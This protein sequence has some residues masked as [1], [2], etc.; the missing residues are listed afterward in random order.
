MKKTAAE[1][2]LASLITMPTISADTVANSMAI[3]YIESYLAKRGMHCKRTEFGGHSTLLASSRPDNQHE[4]VVLLSGHTDVVAGTEEQFHLKIDGDRLIGRGTFDMKFAIA[5]YMQFVDEIKDRLAEYDFAILIVSD[6]ETTDVG[7]QGHIA[8][9]LRPQVCILPDST[10]PNWDIESLAKGYRRLDLIAE[11]KAAHG[12]RPWEGESASL[13]LIQALHELKTH[14]EDQNVA[15]ESLN[16]GKIHGGEAHNMVCAEMTAS[17]DVRFMSE[18]NM[19][20]QNQLIETIC[21]KHGITLR[22]VTLALPAITDLGYPLV[23]QYLDSVEKVTGKRPSEFI[24]CAGSDAPYFQREGIH[25]IVSCCEGGGHHT[26]NEW[27]G[28]KSFAQ[29][30]PIL[31]DYLDK[32]ARNFTSSARKQ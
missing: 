12:G 25:C 5:G 20:S 21:K 32:T 8:A 23:Q 22:E 1:S 17:I 29:F 19:R 27:I 24:S 13:K 16:I 4:P 26:K 18:E 6:E 28:R 3:D 11:G 7:T 2:L 15:S 30:V 10:A 14:F 31:H 9:G